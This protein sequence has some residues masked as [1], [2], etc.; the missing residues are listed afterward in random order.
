MRISD[1]SSDV[2][3]SDLAT[4]SEPAITF[5]GEFTPTDEGLNDGSY[6]AFSG[7]WDESKSGFGR[8]ELGTRHVTVGAAANEAAQE[9]CLG[10]RTNGTGF[11]LTGRIGDVVIVDTFDADHRTRMQWWLNGASDNAARTSVDEGKKVAVREGL[12]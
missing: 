4:S 7:F 3:S 11:L 2:C 8:D 5:R 6:H 10:A 1:W 12:G 9:I